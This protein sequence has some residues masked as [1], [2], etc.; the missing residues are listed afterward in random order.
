VLIKTIDRGHPCALAT[1]LESDGSTPVKAGAKAVLDE[2][3][4]VLAGTVGGGMVEA[5]TQR[6][7]KEAIQAGRA[8]LFDVQLQGA[9]AHQAEPI[10]GGVMRVLVDP[11]VAA[12][13]AAYDAARQAGAGRDRG[14]LLTHLQNIATP[15][16]SVEW[17]DETGL[18]KRKGFPGSEPI[19]EVLR[20]EVG[21]FLT[22]EPAT[23]SSGAAAAFIEPVLPQ[24]LL[25]IVG[26]GHVGQAVAQQAAWLGFQVKV[27][28]DRE[29]YAQ[30]ALFPEDTHTVCGNVVER[31]AELEASAD[32][33]VVLVSRGHLHDAEALEVCIRKPFAYLG[34]I[35][36]K[37]KVAMLRQNFIES[38]RATPAEF[39]RVYTPIGLDI[40]AVTVPEI[41]SSIVTQ[42]IS[43]RRKGTATRMPTHTR[44]GA[45]S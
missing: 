1:V 40:G 20:R 45:T 2:A 18:D 10:C 38:G 28:E 30:P 32:T 27:I 5:T 11:T 21:T 43:V 39:D 22:D 19:R 17:V 14:V 13:R 41:A 44:S 15:S 4:V 8:L 25:V 34:M 12:H 36:S 26:G 33:Y 23:A 29:E 24:P 7:A 16:V 37:R 9:A 42:L 31:L 6:R 3:G 35:G